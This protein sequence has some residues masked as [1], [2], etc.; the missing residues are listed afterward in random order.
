MAR[1]RTAGEA[2]DVTSSSCSLSSPPS[3][4]SEQHLLDEF[5]SIAARYEISD[6]FALKLRQL[7]G[8]EIVLICDDSGSM[9]TPVRP[10]MSDKAT[11]EAIRAA[12][13]QPASTRWQELKQSVGIIVDLA[14][15]MDKDGSVREA[16]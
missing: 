11:P 3:Y 2:D 4:R 7:E 5:K 13:F 16:R 15:V 9:S 10:G 6:Y 14:A 8:F 1:R 12:A